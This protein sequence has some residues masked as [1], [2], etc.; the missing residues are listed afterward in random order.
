MSLTFEWDPAKSR[1]NELK[2][3]VSFREAVTIFADP[4]SITTYDPD[5]SA[6][7]DRFITIGESDRGRLL[8]VVHTD[9]ED[10]IRVISARKSKRSERVAYEER[11]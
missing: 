6:D 1:R 2:H 3:L 11:I 4:G 8:V 10:T 5:H 7:E 9:R